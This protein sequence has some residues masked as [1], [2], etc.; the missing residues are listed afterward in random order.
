MLVRESRTHPSFR[1][2]DPA[3]GREREEL[4][5]WN[6]IPNEHM[7]KPY[8]FARFFPCLGRESVQSLAGGLDPSKGICAGHDDAHPKKTQPPSGPSTSMEYA[9]PH[10]SK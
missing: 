4:G 1:E 2:T 3:R 6:A 5:K 7:R 10:L 8:L 9:G